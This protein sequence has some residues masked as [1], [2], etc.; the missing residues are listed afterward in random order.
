MIALIDVERQNTISDIIKDKYKNLK[1][2][3]MSF[4]QMNICLRQIFVHDLKLLS[5]IRLIVKDVNT[6]SVICTFPDNS[7]KICVNIES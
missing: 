2:R 1:E 3:H 4:S 6:L 5:S 7:R